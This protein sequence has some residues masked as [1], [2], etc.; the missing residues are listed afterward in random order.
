MV[1]LNEHLLSDVHEVTTPAGFQHYTEEQGR[2]S[3]QV[4]TLR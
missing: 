4:F 1:E 2:R 3:G